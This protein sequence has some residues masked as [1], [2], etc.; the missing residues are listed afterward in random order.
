MSN[1]IFYLFCIYFTS[2]NIFCVKEDLYKRNTIHWQSSVSST[3]TVEPMARL[4][5][6]ALII[7][8]NVLMCVLAGEIK[9]YSNQYINN[10]KLES[11]NDKDVL[12]AYYKCF[13]K[14]S[15]CQTPEQE[16]L[17]GIYLY[18]YRIISF[19]FC[20]G[21]FNQHEVNCSCWP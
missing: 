11:L 8:M 21:F 1:L 14:I 5:Q 17:I 6:I 12:E 15:P 20:D 4:S 2:H 13:M 18:Y 10:F 3:I 9:F 7:V 16:H 19:F